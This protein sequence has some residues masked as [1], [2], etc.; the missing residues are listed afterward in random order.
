[1]NFSGSPRRWAGRRLAGATV[2]DIALV[3]FLIYELLMLIRGTR[4]VQMALSGG[5]LIGSVLPVAA[6]RARDGQLGDPQPGRLRR[7]RG[8]R[9]VP[10]RHPPRAGALRPRAVLPL[11][12]KARDGGRD[13]RRAG[14]GGARRC[15]RQRTGAII[16]IERQ[17]G[18]RNYIEGG[19]P[20]DAT[21][22][23][24]LLVTIFQHGVAA[25]RRRGRSSRATASRRPPAS[26]RCRSIP[27]SAGTSA[28]GIA[29]R[30]ASPR[31]T[32]RS[33]SS[34]PRRPAGS[35]SCSTG[36]SSAA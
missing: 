19:I 1:M 10:V 33:P 4:A 20:L 29:R 18:L 2:V 36:E 14:G 12:A 15:R 11:S 6:G 35:R 34:C 9:A 26:C 17:I 25:A 3:S 16:V 13:D 28:R 30:S 32:T 31:R 23:Y 24:D 8:H 22:T 5:L 27:R 21:V 7:L